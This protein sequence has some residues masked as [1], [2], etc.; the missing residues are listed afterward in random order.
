MSRSL[1]HKTNDNAYK[2]T[3]KN[4]KTD[5]GG[6]DSGEG[7]LPNSSEGLRDTAKQ[8]PHTAEGLRDTAKRFPHTAE[9]LRDGAKR[10]PHTAEGLRDT[11]KRFPHTAEDLR[12]TVKRF[13]HTAEGRP[14]LTL[15]PRRGE[16]VRNSGAA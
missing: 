4:S 1:F 11:V 16:G 12:D 13:P 3:K 5:I 8:F 14:S 10:F 15:S 7:R 9:G 6:P 2:L